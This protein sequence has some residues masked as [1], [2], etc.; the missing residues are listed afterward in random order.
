[1]Y[2]EFDVDECETVILILACMLA[3][4]RCT[5][6]RMRTLHTAAALNRWTSVRLSR[7]LLED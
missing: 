2:H 7:L 1:M 5:S 3:L 6:Y 4:L